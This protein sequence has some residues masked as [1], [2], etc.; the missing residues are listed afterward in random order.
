MFIQFNK[1][2]FWKTLDAVELKWSPRMTSCA[3]VCSYEGKGSLCSIRLSLPLLKLRPRKDLVETLLHEMIHAFLFITDNDRDRD[4]HG[5]Q[6]RKHMDRI[7]KEAGT[8]ITIYHTFHAEV[9]LYQQHWWRCDGPCQ[10]Q[11]PFFGTVKRAMNRPPGPSDFWWAKHQ[12][13]CGGKFIKVREPVGFN[14][15]AKETSIKGTLFEVPSNYDIRRFF[16][17]NGNSSSTSNGCKDQ[18][19][20]TQNVDMSGK[21]KSELG[22]GSLAIKRGGS[23]VLA[24]QG[25]NKYETETGVNG[26]TINSRSTNWVPSWYAPFNGKGQQPTWFS[27]FSGKGYTLSGDISHES[28]PNKLQSTVPELKVLEMPSPAKRKG[29]G[30]KKDENSKRVKPV[31]STFLDKWVTR[32]TD[33]S[34]LTRADE[35]KIS[36]PSCGTLIAETLINDHLDS[37][38]LIDSGNKE[39]KYNTPQE[40]LE[41]DNLT[42]HS[43]GVNSSQNSDEYSE[44]NNWEQSSSNVIHCPVCNA[45]VTGEDLDRHLETC[46]VPTETGDTI[47][48]SD[49]SEEEVELAFSCPCCGEN[50]KENEMNSHLDEC[51]SL[52][53][54]SSSIL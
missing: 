54:L 51:L 48:I 22:S 35:R 32:G 40:R 41:E 52:P 4:G 5:P 31:S 44:Y 25:K 21:S 29:A 3:G 37:C 28:T 11:R 14:N 27:A 43:S 36:C 8:N 47:V 15:K 30:V 24:S 23:V 45:E 12:A 19:G 42:S 34:S 18:A 49:S 50:I 1:R 46:M 13:N 2:F 10:K 20:V 53:L 6:F 9:E 33:S 7:N 26:N 17:T 16:P 38:L 39:E